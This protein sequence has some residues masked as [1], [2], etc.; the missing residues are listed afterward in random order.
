MKKS[1]IF[2][3]A[4]VC[5][6]AVNLR[7]QSDEK[8]VL[9]PIGFGI[10]LEQFKLNDISDLDLAPVNKIIFTVNSSNLFRIEPEFGFRSGEDSDNKKNK[11]VNFGLG[12]F[13]MGQKNKLN[14]YGGV[15]FEYG[16]MTQEDEITYNYP[17]VTKVENKSKRVF[18][19]PALGGE[20][21][22]AENFSIAGE[23]SIMIV[24]LKNE[25][26]PNLYSQ[27]EDKSNYTSTS[28]GL[29]FRFYF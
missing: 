1:T 15:R 3:V 24:S 18:F 5:C 4:L 21:F 29:F 26:D 17:N 14:I 28:T 23:F 12:L 6:F 7:A 22:F 10:H 27:P 11:M 8:P 9:R 20:Y 2:L 16:V 19:G 25:V 13:L